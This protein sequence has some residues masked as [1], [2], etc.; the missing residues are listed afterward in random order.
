MGFL[1]EAYDL[2]NNWADCV[3]YFMVL[4]YSIFISKS[5]DDFRLLLALFFYTESLDAMGDT[6]NTNEVTVVE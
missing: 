1:S 4:G 6:A 2:N 5:S 3:L